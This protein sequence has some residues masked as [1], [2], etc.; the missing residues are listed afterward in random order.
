[1]AKLHEVLDLAQKITKESIL[2]NEIK[3]GLLTGDQE[4][5]L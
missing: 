4:S 3:I 2:I 5:L 1:M